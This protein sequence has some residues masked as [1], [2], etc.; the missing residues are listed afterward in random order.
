MQ[1]PQPNPD[2]PPE[3]G[4]QLYEQ[5]LSVRERHY[6]L[7]FREEPAPNDAESKP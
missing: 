2:P 6:G 5:P 7:M 3:Y 4:E 1:Q